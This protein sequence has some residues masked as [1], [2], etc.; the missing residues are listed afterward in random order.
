MTRSVPPLGPSPDELAAAFAR[1]VETALER[2]ERGGEAPVIRQAD[3]ETLAAL[4]APPPAAGRALDEALARLDAALSSGMNTDHPRFF[5]FIPSPASPL[6]W[7]GELAASIHNQHLGAARQSEGATAIERGLIRWL[8]GEAGM[9]EGA[10]GLFVSGGSI[11]NLTALT[12]ARDQMLVEDERAQGT[13]YVTAETH[14]SVAKALRIIGLT[15]RQI[16]VAPVDG[17]RRMDVAGLARVIAE[18]RAAG[19]KP[20]VVAATAGTTNTGAID[21]LPEI[22]DLCEREGLWM[23]VDG[24]Y[25]ASALLSPAHR[26]L[27]EGVGRADSLS[28]DAHKWLF[29]TYGCGV[30]LLRDASLLAPSFSLSADYL[31]DGDAVGADPNFWDLGPELTRSARAVRLWLTLQAMGRDGMAAAIAH[32]FALAEATERAVRE[33]PDW[34]VASPARMAITAFRYV[35]EGLATDTADAINAAA[36]R[37]LME[38]GYAAVGATRLDGRVALRVCAINPRA[39]ETDMRE[40]IRRLDG[41]ARDLRGAV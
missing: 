34:L 9:P 26:D 37:R 20:F 28:W 24:A 8:A 30:A 33:T 35:P 40:T 36:A 3:P 12:A 4:A 5:A 6:S 18:D 13:A 10:G 14:A 41:I 21:P 27:L 38:E 32:G 17:E 39:T 29:Q 16:R 11:A 7:L 31:R 23:H 2:A 1:L 25:G 15:D 19:L 22:A